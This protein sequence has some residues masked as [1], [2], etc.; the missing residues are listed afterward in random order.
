MNSKYEKKLIYGFANPTIINPEN[1]SE[2]FIE[3]IKLYFSS[4]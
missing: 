2:R 3:K 1:Y 4:V